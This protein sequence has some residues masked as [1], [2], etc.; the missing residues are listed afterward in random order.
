M[1]A[2]SHV[3]LLW[4]PARTDGDAFELFRCVQV[5][6]NNRKRAFSMALKARYR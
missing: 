4:S 3:S 1:T 6:R 2:D 5:Y